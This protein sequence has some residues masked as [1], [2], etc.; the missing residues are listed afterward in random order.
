MGEMERRAFRNWV[1]KGK[2]YQTLTT[3]PFVGECSV[4]SLKHGNEGVVCITA[5]GP[6]SVVVMC[7]IEDR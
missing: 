5:G 2:G 3:G 4:V 6:H 7:G 1:V